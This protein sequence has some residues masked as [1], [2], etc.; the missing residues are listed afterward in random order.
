[1]TPFVFD[2]SAYGP[3][4]AALLAVDRLPDLGP[5]TPDEARRAAI[6]TAANELPPAYAAGLWL[7]FD[8]LDECHQICQADEGNP[9]RD[10]WHA[11]MHRREPD[12]VNSKY[13]WRRVGPHPVVKQLREHAPALGYAYTTPEAFVDECE[14]VRDWEI[15]AETTA[16]RVQRLEWELMFDHS[17]KA[18][19]PLSGGG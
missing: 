19:R 18:S 1:M 13:W 6:A 16:R 12:A 17:H 9:D 5:G 3:A 15:D 2:P 10:F 7:R 11:V 8:F 4:V 14:R